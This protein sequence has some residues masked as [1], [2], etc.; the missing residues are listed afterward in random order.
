MAA[1]FGW[2]AIGLTLLPVFAAVAGIAAII[3][4]LVAE[5]REKK[6]E[7]STFPDSSRSLS[8]IENLDLRKSQ[9]QLSSQQSPSPRKPLF[10]HPPRLVTL[11]GSRYP[12][13]TLPVPHNFQPGTANSTVC[14]CGFDR[15]SSVHT[16]S[17]VWHPDPTRYH[18]Y[19]SRT[20]GM[21]Q[22]GKFLFDDIHNFQGREGNLVG[23]PSSLKA[24]LDKFQAQMKQFQPYLQSPTGQN[25]GSVRLGLSFE[26]PQPK[27]PEYVYGYR[28]WRLEKEMGPKRWDVMGRTIQDI[29]QI[30]LRPHA[31]SQGGNWNPG[32]N[33]ASCTNT[34]QH[35]DVP[36]E[37]CH[38][39]FWCLDDLAKAKRRI[40]KELDFINTDHVIGSVV[41]MGKCIRHSDGWRMEQ[42]MVVAFVDPVMLVNDAFLVVEKD[43]S[44]LFEYA[45]V[46][47][48]LSQRWDVPL[49]T[50]DKVEEFTKSV[51]EAMC[52]K[53][54]NE[55]PS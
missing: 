49:V 27:M 48:A 13:S 39:G 8:R 4:D 36:Q 29:G 16:P 17:L 37:G 55:R 35:R 15:I 19:A 51:V 3:Y 18:R 33:V 7:P 38:C 30:R 9:H 46:L 50:E 34:L 25:L 32:V 43:K 44:T 21:C 45:A 20:N 54:Q 47:K 10:D 6:R 52:K 1:V 23:P 26:T 31:T 5:W 2:I 12:T 22:C 42:A 11:S 24:E 14:T 41:G 53:A 28:V 40:A